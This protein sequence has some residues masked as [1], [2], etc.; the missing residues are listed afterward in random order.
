[1]AIE[2]ARG[3]GWVSYRPDFRDYTPGH[4]TILELTCKL[5][6]ERGFAGAPP[7]SID[8]RKWCAPIQNQG[9]LNSCRANAA[10]GIIQY[11]Q[12][13]A[14]GKYAAPSRLFIYRATRNLLHWTG[15]TGANLRTTMGTLAMFGAHRRNTGPMSRLRPTS[16]KNPPHFVTRCS[17]KDPYTANL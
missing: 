9:S 8:L 13:R 7:R 3:M 10:S 14:Y 6:S 5:K 16:T 1:M 2:A 15:D 11:F 12:N 17:A 4:P